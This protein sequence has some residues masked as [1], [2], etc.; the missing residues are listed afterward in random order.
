MPT[1][2]DAPTLG[3]SLTLNNRIVMAPMTRTRTSEG[4]VPNA[5]MAKY[6]GQ[7]ASAGL[8]V[9]E[10]TDVSAHSKGYA[11]TPGIYTDA[12]VEGW[13]L[14][15]DEVHHNGGRIFLQVWHVGRMAHTSLMPNGEAPWG[16]TDEKASESDVFAHDSDGKL[17]FMRASPPRQIQVEEI[18]G[19]VN[20][21]AL[22]FKNA[23]LAGFD[24][25]EIHAA[26]GYLFDQFMNSALNTRTD[27][28]GGATP[29]TRTRLLLEVVDAA[30]RELGAGK[31]GV[32]VSPFGRYNSMPADPHVEETLLYLSRELSRRK[33]AYLHMLYQLMPSGNMEDSEFNETH[34]RDSFVRK[35]REAFDGSLIW[36]GG[37]NRDNAQVALDTGWVDLIAFGRPFVANPDLAVRFR[38][39]WPLAESDRSVLYTR[40]GEKGYT[41]FSNFTL[42]EK[43]GLGWAIEK[44]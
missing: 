40:N 1:L 39:D 44:S 17:T 42:L 5:L 24:G 28:Y 19:L 36:C 8:I 31:V 25:V 6:Y 35:V 37:F 30:I 7:R 10:A 33:V 14:V 12:Q 27:E 23:K 32:R 43:P 2:F 38:N 20:E 3:S 15:T 13:K 22:A 9:T 16:V 29:E 41:D 21:F 34:L 26:N 18:P 4:D 11:W